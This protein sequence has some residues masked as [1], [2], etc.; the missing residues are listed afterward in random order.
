MMVVTPQYYGTTGNLN[1]WGGGDPS[2]LKKF[3]EYMISKYRIN[4]SRIYLTGLSH[5]GNGV[6]DYISMVDDAESHIAA[7]APVASYGARSG[8]NKSNETPIWTFA[9]EL[10][11]T[12]FATS[13]NF[14]TKYNAQVPAPLFKAKISGYVGVGHD[15]WTRTYDGTGIG[16][17]DPLYD[18]FNQSLYDWFFKYKRTN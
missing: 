14:V 5:G 1:N 4:P 16:T 17:S 18:L 9:G 11:A 8:F 3:I 10:D 13:K 7:A 15:C 6:Y 12:N 2:N